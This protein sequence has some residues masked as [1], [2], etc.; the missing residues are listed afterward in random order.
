M[1]TVRR[2][3]GGGASVSLTPSERELLARLLDQFG[4][5]LEGD[6]LADPAVARLFPAGYRDD[7]DAAD[8]FRRY[9][10][11]SLLARKSANADAVSAAIISGADPIVLTSEAAAP[12][13]PLLTDLRL[14]IAE[15]LGIRTEEDSPDGPLADVYHW[16]GELQ[17]ML[18]SAID[19][20]RA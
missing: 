10:R 1:T 17:W 19:G 4:G 16:L 18:V 13:L 15:R 3:R 8:E 2:R 6:E 7:A 14:V 20:R 5:V 11:G 9:T 12:W